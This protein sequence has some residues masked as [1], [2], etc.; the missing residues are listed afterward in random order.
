VRVWPRLLPRCRV[1]LS[2]PIE[3]ACGARGQVGWKEGRARAYSKG[4][5]R[6]T[7][8]WRRG[9]RSARGGL[10]GC[11]TRCPH[12]AGWCVAAPRQGHA[13]QQGSPSEPASHRTSR[14]GWVRVSHLGVGW[15]T[16]AE[17][18]VKCW[19]ERSSRRARRRT[20]ASTEQNRTSCPVVHT[21]CCV[22]A[23]E[24]KHEGHGQ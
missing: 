19:E 14:T 11:C 23:G 7:Q 1:V 20:L 13:D 12:G 22:Q 17:S 2:I 9:G 6:E 24:F 10:A 3:R 18:F 15:R 8:R 16:R 21:C 4:A 5:A